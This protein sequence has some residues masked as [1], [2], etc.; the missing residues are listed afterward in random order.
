MLHPPGTHDFE[1]VESRT[2]MAVSEVL[3]LRIAYRTVT[4]FHPH[5]RDSEDAADS[6]ILQARRVVLDNI[7]C[8]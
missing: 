1:A 4:Q 6:R 7:A 2:A 5:E 3:G 8:G